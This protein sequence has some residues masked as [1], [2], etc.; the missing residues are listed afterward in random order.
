MTIHLT[1]LKEEKQREI[2]KLIGLKLIDMSQTDYIEN[3]ECILQYLQ[4]GALEP[5]S[6]QDFFGT[7]GWEHWL[8][9]D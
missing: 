8:G 4:D 7:E 9:L 1:D 5:L 2:L 6:E 3:V